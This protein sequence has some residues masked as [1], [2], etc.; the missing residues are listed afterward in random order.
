VVT[1][2]TSLLQACERVSQAGLVVCQVV[3]LLD[4]GEG[5]RE[6]LLEQGYQLEALYTREDLLEAR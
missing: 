5:G 2:G 6:A 4:R 3:C 1:T